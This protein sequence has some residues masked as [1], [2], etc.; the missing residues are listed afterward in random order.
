M[1]RHIRWA[2]FA[3]LAMSTAVHADDAADKLAAQKKQ[4]EA[5]WNAVEAGALASLET[6]HLILYAPKASEKNLKEVGAYLEKHYAEAARALGYDAKTGPWEGKLAVYLFPEREQFAAFVRRVGKRRFV[7]GET[8]SNA[9]EGDLLHA[10]VG[11][12]AK[13]NF[14]TEAQAGQQVAIAMLRLKAGAKLPLPEWLLTGFGRAT[15][16]R[17]TPQDKYVIADRKLARDAVAKKRTAKAV[18]TETV[19][20]DELPALA[21]A[22]ADMLA[23]GPGST[24]FSELLVGFKPTDDE[25]TKRTTEEALDAAGLK[26]DRLEAAWKVWVVNPK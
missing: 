22:L 2:L 6:P 9:V 17:V 21:G 14:P 23:Y 24:K 3:V 7:A 8:A 15:T 16:Y 10:A 5:N 13:E 20:A 18:Y 19:D 11:P 25:G 1:G 26:L 4:A 12:A